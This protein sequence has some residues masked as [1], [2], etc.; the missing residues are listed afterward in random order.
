MV[1]ALVALCS[2]SMKKT[3]SDCGL[4]YVRLEEPLV[5]SCSNE[6][7]FP[8]V[9]K[10]AS[11]WTSGTQF[12]VLSVYTKQDWKVWLW[13]QGQSEHSFLHC[14]FPSELS[15]GSGSGSG[16]ACG[17]YIPMVCVVWYVND[18][19]TLWS[20]DLLS[21]KSEIPSSVPVSMD[22]TTVWVMQAWTWV[23]RIFLLHIIC[24]IE[25]CDSC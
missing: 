12:P 8:L 6:R 15:S 22:S 23:S 21:I 20:L 9:T 5:L 24:S 16:C 13:K 4:I 10:A 1:V 17:C 3:G 19:N 14:Q 11:W 18:H 25:C 2:P 7:F